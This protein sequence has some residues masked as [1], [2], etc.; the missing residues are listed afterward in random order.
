MLTVTR[1]AAERGSTP[2]DHHGRDRKH[3]EDC[4]AKLWEGIGGRNQG[5]EGRHAGPGDEW[6]GGANRSTDGGDGL[7]RARPGLHYYR[8]ARVRHLGVR[9]VHG[10]AWCAS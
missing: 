4:R 9:H 1:M 5:V 2:G 3:Q 7:G 6:I 8:Y 10:L